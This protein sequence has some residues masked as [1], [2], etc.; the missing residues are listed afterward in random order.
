MVESFTNQPR[1]FAPG[2]R[3]LVGPNATPVTVTDASPY[4]GRL[5]VRLD[6]VTDRDAAE[7]L[8]RFDLAVPDEDVGEPPPGEVWAADLE[9]LPVVEGSAAGAVI[10]TV[11]AVLANPAHDL[12]VVAD[13]A[14]REF[15][16]PLVEA[17]VDEILP[18]TDSVV[19]HPI[20]GMLPESDD[21]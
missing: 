8:R 20:P 11:V 14:G 6:E 9:G 1:R 5:L 7:S 18:G 21:G 13:P 12:L 19:V 3:L 4:K 16:I 17:F 15:M 10:G 2:S